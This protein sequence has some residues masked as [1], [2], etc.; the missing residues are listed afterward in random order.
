MN[1]RLRSAAR[2]YQT[3][4]GENGAME[5]KAQKATLFEGVSPFAEDN[6]YL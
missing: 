4:E 5:T 2:E 1:S 3:E 6:L